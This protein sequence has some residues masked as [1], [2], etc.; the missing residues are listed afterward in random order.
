MLQ[1]L[2]L[3]IAALV[4]LSLVGA[5][6]GAHD[7]TDPAYGA[8]FKQATRDRVEGNEFWGSKRQKDCV[9]GGTLEVCTPPGAGGI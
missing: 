8:M 4:V 9:A 7:A 5:G 6:C 2:S 1:S 3:R